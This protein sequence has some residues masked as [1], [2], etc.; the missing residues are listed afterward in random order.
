MHVYIINIYSLDQT[1]IPQGNELVWAQGYSP[2]AARVNRGIT[3]RQ[4]TWPAEYSAQLGRAADP[5]PLGAGIYADS[6]DI[7]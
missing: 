7:I 1:N 2:W 3:L 4:A 6:Q 5:R